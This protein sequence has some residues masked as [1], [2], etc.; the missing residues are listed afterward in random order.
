VEGEKETPSQPTRG[1]RNRTG[2]RQPRPPH[3]LTSGNSLLR[4]PAPL[5]FAEELIV[6]ESVLE[7]IL[8]HFIEALAFTFDGF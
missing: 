1:T 3:D 2:S 5:Y 8:N 6:K 7:K 4:P